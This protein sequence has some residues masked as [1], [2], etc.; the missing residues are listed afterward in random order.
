MRPTLALPLT[1]ELVE[2]IESGVSLLV[3]TRDA[4]LRPECLRGVGAAVSADRKRLT[5]YLSSATAERTLSNLEQNGEIAVSFSR[6]IDH[7]TIQAKGKVVGIRPSGP[8]DRLI[9]ERYLASFVEQV[10]L[11]GL[12]RTITRRLR[13]SPSVA[14]DFEIREMFAQTPGPGAGRRIAPT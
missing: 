6:I 11:V 12:P 9:Q 14:V 1:E 4:S 3:G 10:Y 8:D 7:R 2:F 13:I 5:V